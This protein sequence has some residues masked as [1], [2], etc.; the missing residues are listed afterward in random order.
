MKKIVLSL[1]M[2]VFA[3]SYAQE[4]IAYQKPDDAILRL[5]DYKRPPS[6]SMSKSRDWMLFLER[7]TY[8]TLEDL[9]QDEVRLGGLRLNPKYSLSSSVFFIDT[10][11]YKKRS[12]RTIRQIQNLPANPRITSIY[13]SPDEKYL[14]FLNAG[15]NSLELWV[16]DLSTGMAKKIAENINAAIGSAVIWDKNSERMLVRFNPSTKPELIDTSRNIPDGPVVSVSS[17]KVSQNR[18]YQDLIKNPT[19]EKNFETLVTAQLDWVGLNG[20][21]KPFLPADLYTWVQQ[22]PDG[23]AYLVTTLKK[24]F[25][26]IVPYSRFPMQQTVYSAEGKA[27]KTV[28]DIP[29]NEVMPKGFSSVRKGKRSMGWMSDR[30]ASLLYAVA[31]DDGDQSKEVPFRDEIFMWNYPFTQS[32]I[33]IF[34]TPLRFGGVDYT[35]SGDLLVGDSWYDTR[36]VHTYLVKPETGNSKT[37]FDRNYQD[38]YS[39]PGKFVTAKNKY[40]E[41]VVETKNGQVLLIGDGYTPKGQFPFIDKMTLADG[42]KQRLYT[43][44]LPSGKED[45]VD[46]LDAEKGIILTSRESPVLYPNLYEVKMKTKK[47]VPLTQFNNPF[48]ALDGVQ[49]E[50]V[51]YKRADGVD[52]SGTLYL[53]KGF[54]KNNP[55]EKLPLLIWAYPAE[56]KDKNT[57][58]QNTQN[59]NSFTYPYYGS[60][61]YW[62]NKG[63]AVLDD[64]SF[65]II[66][67][68]NE[69][70]NDTFIKQL[71]LNAKAAID[72]LNNKGYIDPKRVAIGGHSYGAFMTANLLTH[73]DLF[74]C[75]IARSGAYNRTLTPFG[76]Q[77]EQRNYWDNPALYNEMSP[78]M[79]ADKMKTPLLLVHGAADNNPGTFTLQTERYFEALKN[80]GAPVRMVLLPKESHGYQAKENIFHLLWEQD[81]FLEKC[82]KPKEGEKVFGK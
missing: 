3:G 58:G 69:E 48:S 39:D 62:V 28:N 21:R 72:Y 7:P 25:S 74:A 18:T 14:S 64:A 20:E 26:Y 16:A 41:D 38:V 35:T 79:H 29:L 71:V 50:V 2:L 56:Y 60:F 67:E 11:S 36:Q 55:K 53:P 52:L 5:A 59:A 61:V 23:S 10:I 82:L 33:S 19:D 78:F 9:N 31:L 70:P 49:K 30:P 44:A 46:V 15:K 22:S 57:A 34:R 63:Y 51:T 24:P 37:L 43:S 6:V 17:G 66:G 75:G 40:G 47:A 4:N 27:V 8:K 65:P 81:Q 45:I 42:K 13:F 32:P 76:F 77:S 54:N 12:E 73:S 80:L 1:C 68:K